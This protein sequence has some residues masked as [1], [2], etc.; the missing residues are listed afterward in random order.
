M[1]LLISTLTLHTSLLRCATFLRKRNCF[2]ISARVNAGACISD[3]YRRLID[4]MAVSEDEVASWELEE[5]VK[6]GRSSNTACIFCAP[7]C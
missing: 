3:Q 5:T 7:L 1:S 6:C 4:L 2:Q